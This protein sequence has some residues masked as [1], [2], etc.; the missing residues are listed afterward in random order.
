MPPKIKNWL[1]ERG[2]SEEVISASK[3]EYRNNQIVIPV[4]DAQNS[5]LFNKYRR[6]PFSENGPKYTYEAGAK[7]QLYMPSR[8]NGQ[9]DAVYIVE[10]ELDALALI[11]RGHYA[12]SSTGGA[13]TFR[14]EWAKQFE[15][16]TIY[17]CYDNDEA[18]L[19]GTLRLL[20]IFPEAFVIEIPKECGKDVTDYLKGYPNGFI[21]LSNTA[22]KWRL[23]PP[24]SPELSPK[25]VKAGRSLCRFLGDDMLKQRQERMME[26]KSVELIDMLLAEITKRS[27][28]YAVR[29][30]HPKTQEE[31]DALRRAKGVPIT[32]Y[33]Q[34]NRQ[35]KALCL[36]HQ[37]KNASM[38]Y[39]PK[40]NRVKCFSCGHLGDVI[41]VVEEKFLLTKGEAIRKINSEHA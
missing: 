26:G 33:V 2:I 34:F 1:L 14:K 39:Y 18:G 17:I 32:E 12:V 29:V 8:F 25:E 15:T 10:G 38:V 16:N 31:S 7:A 36:W 28:E 41:D 30:K 3:L 21:G 13:G 11:S 40:D 9:T 37:E 5:F 23:P 22:E 35:R 24:F 19:T 6:S 4:F 20:N 27:D